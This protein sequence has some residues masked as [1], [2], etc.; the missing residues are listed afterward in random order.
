MSNILLMGILQNE[1]F[2]LIRLDVKKLQ[3]QKL[4]TS[5]IVSDSR[6]NGSDQVHVGC[7]GG[8]IVRRGYITVVGVLI[9]TVGLSCRIEMWA[10]MTFLIGFS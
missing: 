1:G 2:Q 9:F 5:D 8:L 6:K 4:V 7:V 3:S 10:M